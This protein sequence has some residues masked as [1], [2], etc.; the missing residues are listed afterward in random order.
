MKPTEIN[1]RKY[2]QEY[3]KRIGKNVEALWKNADLKNGKVELMYHIISSA[4]YSSNIEGNPLDLNSYMNFRLA[5]RKATKMEK[6]IKDLEQAYEF[7]KVH[8]FSEKN[9]LQAHEKLSATYLIKSKRGKY[10]TGKIG[11]FSESGLVYLAVEPELVKKEMKLFF[12]SLKKILKEKLNTEK[13]FYFASLYHLKFV[14]IHPF[15]DG[16]GRAARLLEKWF[17]AKF[18]GV[19]A[20]KI[21]SEQFYKEHQQ[22]YYNNINLGVNYYELNY[23]KCLPFLEM[24]PK[25]LKKN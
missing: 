16:N 24:L 25:A 19:N 2:F 23:D 17:L 18:L 6:E 10:R 4:V 11:V 21:S 7:A 12:A 20:W 5:K 3:H 15:A 1:D 22:E 8:A 14:H 13:A 9:F